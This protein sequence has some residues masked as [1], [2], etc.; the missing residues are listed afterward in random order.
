MFIGKQIILIFVLL[1]L[2]SSTKSSL[3]IRSR[4]IYKPRH[5]I[6]Q[7]IQVLL[8]IKHIVMYTCTQATSRQFYS[9][10]VLSERRFF[11]FLLF[12]AA[13]STVFK[14][15]CDLLWLI[16]NLYFQKEKSTWKMERWKLFYCGY[17]DPCMIF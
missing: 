9:G 8:R 15:Y 10:V 13:K 6:T 16:I 4:N 7:Y 14:V 17:R 11:E 12:F 3:D 5:T 1:K 2:I